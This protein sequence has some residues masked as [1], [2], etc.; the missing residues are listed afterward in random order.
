M[1]SP[2]SLSLLLGLAIGLVFGVTAQI[3]KFCFYR[4]LKQHWEHQ[5]GVQLHSFFFALCVALVGTQLSAALGWIDLNPSIYRSPT[6]SWLLLPLGGVVFGYG[7]ALANGCGA[8]ALVRLGEG[9]LRSLV[10][11]GS[12]G[13][14]A[15]TTLTGL[16]APVRHTLQVSTTVQLPHSSLS[17]LPWSWLWIGL[18]VVL[19]LGY[20]WRA[21]TT[22]TRNRDLFGAAIIGLLIVLGWLSTGWWAADP[23]DPQPLS[24]LSFVVPVGQSIQYSMLATG[25]EAKFAVVVVLGLVLGSLCSALVRRRFQ[26]EGFTTTP[27]LVRAVLG[28]A[29]MGI[30]GVFAVGCTIGQGLSGIS[31]LAYSSMLSLACITLGAWLHQRLHSRP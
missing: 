16:L 29:L 2:H 21:P 12:L 28:G 3:T 9:N 18:L 13:I 25:M 27:Q 6:F 24:S 1:D 20:V 11:L 22:P 10:V 30:G 14:T 26:W 19:L 4:G 7:M 15:L 23:F 17:H 31:T 8:R 5:Q